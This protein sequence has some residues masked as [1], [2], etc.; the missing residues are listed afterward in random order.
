MHC[1][2]SSLSNNVISADFSRHKSITREP[3]SD[4][5]FKMRFF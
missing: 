1:K 2:F 3:Q 4:T 5:K